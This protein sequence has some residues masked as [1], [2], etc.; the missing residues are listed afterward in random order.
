MAGGMQAGRSRTRQA[1]CFYS[2]LRLW[3]AKGRA[4]QLPKYLQRLLQ[5][6]VLERRRDLHPQSCLP[7][8]DDRKA[9]ADNHDAK[10]Q[11]ALALGDGFGCIAEHHGDDGG[12]RGM[13][14]EAEL[15]QTLPHEGHV[16]AQLLHPLRL[17]V[18]D[19]DSL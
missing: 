7:F 12:R 5:M 17:A 3:P 1:G 10:L 11:Q 8:R 14:V 4:L 9:E 16:I 2:T 15:R 6:L 19:L 18:D 13:N